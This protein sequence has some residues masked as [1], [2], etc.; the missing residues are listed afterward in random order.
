MVVLLS[1]LLVSLPNIR[2]P[3]KDMNE[4]EQGARRALLSSQID[5][6]LHL[7]EFL[8]FKDDLDMQSEIDS[9]N[10]TEK[11]RTFDNYE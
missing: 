10:I 7:D 1:A 9:E 4:A 2:L 6:D 8:V 5:E 3:Q 11:V